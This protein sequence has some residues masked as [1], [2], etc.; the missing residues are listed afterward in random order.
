MKKHAGNAV[1]AEVALLNFS[2][3]VPALP[4]ETVA[5]PW[6]S[7]VQTVR[8]L[9]ADGGSHGVRHQA[10]RRSERVERAL[11]CSAFRKDSHGYRNRPAIADPTFVDAA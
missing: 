5:I 1:S 8:F 2:M 7:A 11:P 10:S 9:T 4:A 3:V 6:S